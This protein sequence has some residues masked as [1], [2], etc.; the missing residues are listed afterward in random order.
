MLQTH[1]PRPL[2]YE[3]GPQ[4]EPDGLVPW[5]ELV[6]F[7]DEAAGEL[8]LVE[9]GA[10]ELLE[11]DELVELEPVEVDPVELEPVE[12]DPVEVD[13]V[14]DEPVEPDPVED[15]VEPVVVLQGFCPGYAIITGTLVGIIGTWHLPFWKT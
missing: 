4:V 9:L 7:V 6:W 2:L 1:I 5:L 3:L 8:E 11:D 10:L 12:L 15:E 14:E 13:P